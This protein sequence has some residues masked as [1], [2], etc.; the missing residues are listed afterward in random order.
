MLSR[1]QRLPTL[2]RACLLGLL[3]LAVIGK[4]MSSTMCELHQLGHTI[5]ALSHSQFHEDS[6]AER[7]MDSDHAKGGHGLLHGSDQGGTY[8]DIATVVTVPVVRLKSDPILIPTELPVPPQHI[9]RL[10]RP[11][12]V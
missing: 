3:M 6:S 11:P 2:L 1:F 12:I 4:P 10:F 7:Q 8:A 9:A 5:A